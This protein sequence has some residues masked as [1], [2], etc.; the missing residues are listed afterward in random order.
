[1]SDGR[2]RLTGIALLYIHRD[3]PVNA[4]TVIERFAK[5]KEKRF[6]DFVI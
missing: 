1:M 6:L 5:K 3:I 2:G 4:Q